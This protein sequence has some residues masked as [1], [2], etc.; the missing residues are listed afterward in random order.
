MNHKHRELTN[1][2]L[3]HQSFG[4]SVSCKVVSI[5]HWNRRIFS[6][7][8]SRV[9]RF[10]F[11]SGEFIT[12]STLKNGR[13]TTR[14]F[15]IVSCND[16]DYLEFLIFKVRSGELSGELKNS[17]YNSKLIV[18][19]RSAGHLV[20]ASITVGK[21]LWLLAAGTGV[22]PFISILKTSNLH[23]VFGLIVLVNSCA[24][25]SDWVLTNIIKSNPKHLANIRRL[26]G[27]RIFQLHLVLR[28]P[29][30][31]LA[32]EL[33]VLRNTSFHSLLP[34]LSSHKDRIMVCGG[35]NFINGMES[36][37]VAA[38]FGRGHKKQMGEYTVE[39][40]F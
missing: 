29:S 39:K 9:H 19:K 1:L 6:I 20:L 11:T 26:V 23:Q 4:Y 22:A 3:Y 33:T 25:K 36:Y 10:T 18:G 38:G 31:P 7:V 13:T 14:L 34:L 8:C 21:I 16:D 15:S 24:F 40:A 12:L 32:S 27:T 28:E 2:V 5:K 37:L 35:S 17:G 30:R